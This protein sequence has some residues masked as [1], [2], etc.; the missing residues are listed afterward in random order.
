[1][2]SF[3]SLLLPLMM[4]SRARQRV[5]NKSYDPL[6]ELK[7]SGVVN[8]VLEKVMDVERL[9]IRA[10]LNFQA[11]GSLLLIARKAS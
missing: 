8:V 5:V 4:A 1:M 11:G 3:V 9:A 10:G 7:I 6:V 2:T